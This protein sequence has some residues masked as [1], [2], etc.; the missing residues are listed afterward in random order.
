MKTKIYLL[1]ILLSIVFLTNCTKSTKP[2]SET[3]KVND[4]EF[5]IND[6]IKIVCVELDLMRFNYILYLNNSPYS[7]HICWK[8]RNLY[9]NSKD[10]EFDDA[11]SDA[12]KYQIAIHYVYFSKEY[13]LSTLT[14]KTISYKK[15]VD[16]MQSDYLSCVNDE[17]NYLKYNNFINDYENKTKNIK[18]FKN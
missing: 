18:C 2:W 7:Y 16:K 8:T 9:T 13:V 3:G 11:K 17:N 6:S 14:D 1:T 4:C 12:D 5:I 15:V 10:Y